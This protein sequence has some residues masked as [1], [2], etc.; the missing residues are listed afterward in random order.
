MTLRQSPAAEVLMRTLGLIGG[1]SWESTAT[2]YRLINEGVR[3]RKGGVHSAPLVVFS[4]DFAPIAAAQHEGQ[5]DSIGDRLA[6]AAIRLQGAG[7]AGLV[8]CT[9]TMH[10]VSDAVVAAVSIPLLHIADGV[11][12]ETRRRGVSR[13][14]LLGTRFTMEAPFLRDRLAAAGLDP[15][16]P[17]TSERTEVHRIIYDELCQGRVLDRSRRMY[18]D[19][20]AALR[21][22]GAQAIVLGCTEIGM[23]V[24]QQHTDLPLLDS[25]ELHARRA[26]DFVLGDGP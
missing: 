6:D 17:D 16:V 18:L 4:F 24:S 25:T 1:L 15:L 12:D 13:V 3:A 10:R 23:L 7:A 26:I 8:L 21:D 5:W 9:N 11:I 20:I 2:Y 22:R 14:G 19:A